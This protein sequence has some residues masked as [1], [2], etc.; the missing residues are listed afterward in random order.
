[1]SRILTMASFM[2]SSMVHMQLF[3]VKSEEQYILEVFIS[4]FSASYLAIARV[5]NVL[6]FT[7]SAV[8]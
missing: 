3:S 4:F 6:Q 2:F 8:S 1:M 7:K 5:Y